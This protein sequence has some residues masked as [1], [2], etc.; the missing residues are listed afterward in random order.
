MNKW[1]SVCGAAS[2]R[3]AFAASVSSTKRCAQRSID[4]V[5][6]IPSRLKYYC[7]LNSRQSSD[8]RSHHELQREWSTCDSVDFCV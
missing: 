4:G 1:H 3:R 8:H 7:N 6:R 2:A 5:D